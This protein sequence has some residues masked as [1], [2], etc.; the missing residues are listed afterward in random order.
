M[1]LG[2]GSEEVKDMKRLKI[3]LADDHHMFA[4]M[5]QSIL[6]PRYDVVDTVTDGLALVEAAR[7]LHPDVVV[8]DIG[9]P[10]LN[11]LDAGLQIKKAMPS[12]KLI[13]LTM[14]LDPYLVRQA[15]RIGAT[16]FLLKQGTAKELPEAIEKVICGGSYLTPAAASA[17]RA[18][19]E[20]PP[21]HSDCS[22]EPTPR[23][24]AVIQLLAEGKSM[25]QVA[26]TL[27]ITPRTVAAHKYAAM[28][29]LGIKSSAELVQYA[30][31]SG[32]IY[33]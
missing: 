24:R 22:P 23:Q 30:V 26:D 29:L 19:S 2:A 33:H 28:E 32:M 21:S 25:K 12:V 31:K 1:G 3:L 10:K 14:N 17:L 8:L 20:L 11:G 6:I 7:Q 4:E 27:D 9:M 18:L 5:L 16:G 15:I 13:F